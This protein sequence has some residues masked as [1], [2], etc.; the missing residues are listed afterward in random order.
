MCLKLH[1]LVQ[2]PVNKFWQELVGN[3][4]MFGSQFSVDIDGHDFDLVT[5][6]RNMKRI[7]GLF[8]PFKQTLLLAKFDVPDNWA[9]QIDTK[10]SELKVVFI[11]K[12]LWLKLLHFSWSV[13][14]WLPLYFFINSN[15]PNILCQNSFFFNT[16]SDSCLQ[17]MYNFSGSFYFLFNFGN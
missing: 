5:K 1:M 10:L 14:I 13:M 4:L 9:I 17:Y 11:L 6:N 15:F 16:F 8:C 12:G 3:E 7:L 2:N